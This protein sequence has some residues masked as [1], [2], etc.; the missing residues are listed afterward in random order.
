MS[1]KVLTKRKYECVSACVQAAVN[2]G[3]LVQVEVQDGQIPLLLYKKI[4]SLH[5]AHG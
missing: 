4:K 3:Y 2:V 5:C 1:L